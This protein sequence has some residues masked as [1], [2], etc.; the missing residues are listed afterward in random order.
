[1]LGQLGGTAL[2]LGRGAA[3]DRPARHQ[4]L[5]AAIAWSCDLLSADEQSLFRRLA[6]FVGG[7]TL[8][9]VEAVCADSAG[10]LLDGL[11]SLIAKSLLRQDADAD[12]QPRYLMFETLREYATELLAA[13]GEAEILLRKHAAYFPGLAQRADAGQSGPQEKRWHDCLERDHGNLRAALSWTTTEAEQ[14]ETGLALAGAL[15]WFWESRGHL[16]EGRHWLAEV[17]AVEESPRPTWARAT[18]LNAAGHLASVA[19]DF[20]RALAALDEADA[21]WRGLGDG[22][23][24]ARALATRGYVLHSECDYAR[25]TVAWEEALAVGRAAGDDVRVA[26]VLAFLAKAAQQRGDLEAAEQLFTESLALWRKLEADWGIAWCLYELAS[27]ALARADTSRAEALYRESLELWSNLA[28]ERATLDPVEALAWV[29]GRRGES[30]R[31]ARLF[32]AAAAHRTRLGVAIKPDN[33][34]AH[35][36]AT[37]RV[38]EAL[39]EAAFARFWAEGKAMP[40]HKAIGYALA[41]PELT[42][43]C[44]ATH[45]A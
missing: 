41:Q 18:A 15:W 38:R 42:D 6:V 20:E 34:S 31:A 21:I 40:L 13:S 22:R 2:E 27:M 7:S 17:L 29:A 11:D 25:A 14:R 5:R 8:E 37:L 30:E 28:D 24:L 26:G 9:A 39:G 4:T 43:G 3:R 35:E 19:G 10:S 36:Q 16:V 33:R 1:M 23:G 12:Q 32:G 45:S 44:T